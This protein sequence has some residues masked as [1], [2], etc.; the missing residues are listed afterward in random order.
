MITPNPFFDPN[1]SSATMAP[2]TEN[3]AEVSSP[4][5]IKGNANGIFTVVN[6]VHQDAL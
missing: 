5:K 2:T 1:G 3:A 4:T 6:I